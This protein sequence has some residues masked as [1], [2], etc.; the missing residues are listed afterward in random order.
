MRSLILLYLGGA[1]AY[2]RTAFRAL[3][4]LPD[5]RPLSTVPDFNATQHLIP[6]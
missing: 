4:S 1:L 2:A 3:Q 6:Q 5:R